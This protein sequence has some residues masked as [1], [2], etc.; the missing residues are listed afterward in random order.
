MRYFLPFEQFEKHEKYQ[1]RCVT[2]NKVAGFS[3]QLKVSLL[4]RCFPRFLNCTSDTKSR[5]ASHISI[6][7]FLW[8]LFLDNVSYDNEWIFCESVM[9]IWVHPSQENSL[10]WLIDITE[11]E[12]TSTV[13][14]SIIMHMGKRVKSV[15][16]L[17]RTAICCC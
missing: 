10:Y 5:K 12:F 1:W 13:S 2:F 7:A 8:S 3:L 15:H 4:H 9:F 17:W 11:N 14:F 6:W 16:I